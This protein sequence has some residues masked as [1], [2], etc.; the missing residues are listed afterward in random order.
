MRRV[1][2]V[3]SGVRAVHLV[4]SLP[5]WGSFGP[6]YLYKAVVL[7]VKSVCMLYHLARTS[8][9][10]SALRLRAVSNAL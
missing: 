10:P 3:I 1:W 8:P 4:V 7:D 9:P 5:V 2:T 6:L